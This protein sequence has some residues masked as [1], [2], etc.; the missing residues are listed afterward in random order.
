MK[1]TKL[2]KKD[3]PKEWAVIL[4]AF[5]D[6]RKR[7]AYLFECNSTSLTGRYWSDGSISYYK[8]IGPTGAVQTVANRQDYPFTAPDQE[9][10]LT[11]G[12]QVVQCG[13][14]CGHKG[15]AYLYRKAQC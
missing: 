7:S 1:M 13:I 12:T 8:I 14:F 5:P 15:N 6:Y 11:D 9:V 10:D 3:N 2:T 4:R